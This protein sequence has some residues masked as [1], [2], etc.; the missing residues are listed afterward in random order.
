MELERCAT[1]MADSNEQDQYFLNSLLLE[2]LPALLEGESFSDSLLD[3]FIDEAQ[4]LTEEAESSILSPLNFFGE[5]SFAALDN[6]TSSGP[7]PSVPQIDVAFTGSPLPPAVP[8][9]ISDLN[10]E[11]LL[12]LI[13]ENFIAHPSELQLADADTSMLYLRWVKAPPARVNATSPSQLVQSSKAGTTFSFSV[14]LVAKIA[15]GKFIAMPATEDI[16]L[17]ATMYGIKKSKTSSKQYRADPKAEM[18]LLQNNPIGKPLL[19]SDGS[20]PVEATIKKNE[21]STN[22]DNISLSCGSNAARSPNAPP[23]ARVWDWDYYMKV[24]SKNSEINVRPLVSNTIATDSN[25]SQT[26]EKR[27]RESANM[28]SNIPD[29]K[30]QKLGCSPFVQSYQQPTMQ[31]FPFHS[32]FYDFSTSFKCHVS[33]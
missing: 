17:V 14:Q 3:C 13:D 22:F 32:H 1:E 15:D 28:N 9:S 12:S 21:S 4:K 2:P 11:E 7:V 10:D 19:V 6:S 31:S 30:K 27:K 29:P 23:A 24:S 18:V 26:R 16:N 25:R 33:L 5:E 20:K 8:A